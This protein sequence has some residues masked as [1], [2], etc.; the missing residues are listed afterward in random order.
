MYGG[1][2][3]VYF[4]M[5]RGRM[6]GRDE[7]FS[8]ISLFILIILYKILNKLPRVTIPSTTYEYSQALDRKLDNK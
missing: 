7:L 4:G 3:L 1:W 8:W 6:V 5:R 2:L